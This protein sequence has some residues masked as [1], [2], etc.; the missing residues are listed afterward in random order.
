MTWS[1]RPSYPERVDHDPQLHTDSF[2]DGYVTYYRTTPRTTQ[3]TLTLRY[4]AIPGSDV[5]AMRSTYESVGGVGLV[6]FTDSR[7]ST[8]QYRIGHFSD[9]IIAVDLYNVSVVLVEH[10][11]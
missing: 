11:H 1:Y 5:A 8:R 10:T 4:V 3:R 9:E 7:G 6:S 2:G